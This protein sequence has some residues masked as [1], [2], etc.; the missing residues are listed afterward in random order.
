MQL[1]RL[2]RNSAVF[3][4]C[5]IQVVYLQLINNYE[6][7]YSSCY[8]LINNVTMSTFEFEQMNRNK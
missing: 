4:L 8:K 7:L 2:A 6:N 3:T 5:C 1:T